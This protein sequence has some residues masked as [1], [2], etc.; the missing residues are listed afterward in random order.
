MQAINKHTARVAGI[1]PGESGEV[2]AENPTVKAMLAAGLLV[3]VEVERRRLAAALGP[4]E[5]DKLRA[6]V[7]ELEAALSAKPVASAGD[8]GPAKGK[9]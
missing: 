2:D 9:G 3:D 7:A 8:K 6:R 4:S 1:A 5:E